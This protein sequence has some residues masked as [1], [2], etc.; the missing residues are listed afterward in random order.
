MNN[1]LKEILTSL[2]RGGVKFVVCGGVAAVLH[3]VERLTMDIDLS[4]SM[5]HKNLTA[6]LDIL[7][8]LGMVPRVPVSPESLLD[9][10]KRKI[11]TD[12]KNALV[13][14][15]IDINNPYRQV[16]IF[17]GKDTLYNELI[18]EAVIINFYG[19]EIPVISIPDLIKMKK[20]VNPIR[21]KDI[22]DIREL[23]RLTG[24]N[25]EIR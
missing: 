24:A 25:D 7:K 16:D 13:F 22:S 3:G 14:T 23:Q 17:L 9:P 1:H 21:E 11:M 12:I 5:D 8:Q 10:E 6:L 2:S 19:Y 18:Q 15:F 4:V 20:M